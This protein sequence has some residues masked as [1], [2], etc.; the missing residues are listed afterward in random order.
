LYQARAD[1]AASQAFA[2]K[3]RRNEI[4]AARANQ[5]DDAGIGRLLQKSAPACAS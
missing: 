4:Q 5:N 2:K 1:S 3:K